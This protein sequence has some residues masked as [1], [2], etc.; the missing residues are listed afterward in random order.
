MTAPRRLLLLP[1]DTS[2]EPVVLAE[3][4]ARDCHAEIQRQMA[5]YPGRRIAA[6]WRHRN[7]EWCR[8][9]VGVGGERDHLYWS[10]G[11]SQCAS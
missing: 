9:I 1:A 11:D 7:G 10:K 8:W 3:V 4:G 2:G 5:K 6:E